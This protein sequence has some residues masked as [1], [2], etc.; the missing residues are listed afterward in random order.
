MAIRKLQVVEIVNGS[1]NSCDLVDARDRLSSTMRIDIAAKAKAADSPADRRATRTFVKRQ[2]GRTTDQDTS[3]G[4]SSALGNRDFQGLFQSIYDAAVISDL[5]GNIIDANVRASN[6]FR[7][8][9][10]ELRCLNIVQVISGAAEAALID[11]IR[12]NLVERFILI[13]ASRCLR[14]DGSFFPAEIAVNEIQFSGKNYL[15]FFVRDISWR[16]DTEDRLLV[17]SDAIVN[18]YSGIAICGLDGAIQYVNPAV[19]RMWG[20]NSD[21]EILNKDVCSLWTKTGDDAELRRLIAEQGHPWMIEVTGIRADGSRF[22]LQ[23]TAASNVDGDGRKVGTVFS[24]ED[25]SDRKRAEEAVRETERQRV[26]LESLGTACHHLGQPATV[27][28]A[29][30]GMLKKQ[31]CNADPALNR[32]IESSFE[33]AERLAGILHRL[34]AT[35]EYRTTPYLDDKPGI[36]GSRIIEI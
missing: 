24:F 30:L 9:I 26:M 1:T 3:S 15:C 33:A 5:E 10:D 35:E 8:T 18:S 19:C 17:I 6:F 22:D 27:L 23:A 12:T 36:Q 4:I 20:Y 16:K 11:T 32:I 34:S 21:S 7:Y 31:Y 13:D 29:N 14:K 28:L 25:I 2:V